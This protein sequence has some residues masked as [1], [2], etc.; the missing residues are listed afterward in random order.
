MP[1]II[2]SQ[3]IAHNEWIWDY[4]ESQRLVGKEVWKPNE[5]FTYNGTSY[6]FQ[7]PVFARKRKNPAQGYA[8]EMLSTKRLGAGEYGSVYRIS[9]TM[10][11]GKTNTFQAKDKH[12][13]VKFLDPHH[14][15]NEY[16]VARYA[17]HLHIKAPTQHYLVMKEM[18][19]E[20][21]FSFLSK[22]ALSRQEKLDLSIALAYA[23]KEQLIDIKIIHRDLHGGNI[24]IKYDPQSSQNPFIVNI[25]DYGI[26][27][28]IP[29]LTVYRE[30]YDAFSLCELLE[31]IWA[32]ESDRP[33]YINRLLYLRSND[34]LDYLCLD[35]IVI[36]PTSRSQE[37]LDHMFVY[38]NKLENKELAQELQ[39]NLLTALK[40]SKANNL[41][42]MRQAVQECID[43]LQQHKIDLST[44]PYPIFIEDLEKQKL[45]NDINTYFRLLENKGKSLKNTSQELE[46]EQLCALAHNLRQKTYQAAMMPSHDQRNALVECNEYCKQVLKDNKKLLDIHRDSNYIWAEIGIALCSLI[47]FYPVVGFIHYLATDRFRFFNQTESAA[48]AQKIEK[49]FNQLST[50][51]VD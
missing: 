46:G 48:G 44:F 41:A 27:R 16:E 40:G 43:R 47:V 2:D 30:N 33:K 31:W 51:K 4:L 15:L 42:L 6:T 7:Q 34:I 12:R 36:S 18:P 20:T 21:L 37:P 11:Q 13:V 39:T 23:I 32:N 29:T 17:A 3:N 45:F 5:V 19:G 25:I 50:L 24:L 35:E 22:Y 49:N 10:S 8:Y 38:L 28:Y 26:A 9:C 14:A 1:L